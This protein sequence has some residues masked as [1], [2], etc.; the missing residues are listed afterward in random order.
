LLRTHRSLEELVEA[1]RIEYEICLEGAVDGSDVIRRLVLDGDGANT[2]MC[3]SCAERLKIAADEARALLERVTVTP[4]QPPR[5]AIAAMN[6]DLLRLQAGHLAANELNAVYDAAIELIKRAM[7]AELLADAWPVAI[8]A[9]QSA[10]EVGE[11]HAEAKRLDRDKLQPV[12]GRLEGGDSRLLAEVTDSERLRATALEQ[13]LI[14]AGASADLVRRAQQLRAHASSR[15]AELRAGSR[16]HVEGMVA[17]LHYRLENV[18]QAVAGAVIADEPAPVV[19]DR[20]EERLATNAAAYDPHALLGRDHLLLLGEVCQL[21]D[22][23]KY[24]W[25]ISA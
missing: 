15:M 2:E 11:R 6:R 5:S 1:R 21:S 3:T 22:E 17:D 18:A 14:T 10:A 7:E 9:P 25:G 16:Y 8:I 13:K 24:R 12:F 20:L 23:C 19:W 4:N